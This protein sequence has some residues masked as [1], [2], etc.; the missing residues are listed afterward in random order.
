MNATGVVG[1][2]YGLPASG[3]VRTGGLQR[4]AWRSATHIFW[5]ATTALSDSLSSKGTTVDWFV[6]GVFLGFVKFTGTLVVDV[7]DVA[8]FLT[9]GISE[10]Y[11]FLILLEWSLPAFSAFLPAETVLWVGVLNVNLGYFHFS[12]CLDLPA[13]FSSNCLRTVPSLS[14]QTSFVSTSNCPEVTGALADEGHCL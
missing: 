2:E 10:E 14:A 1:G 3:G 7:L 13:L 11:R 8:L 6:F 9:K 5:T 4:P 12:R